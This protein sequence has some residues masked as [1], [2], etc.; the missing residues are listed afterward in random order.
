MKY[1]ILSLVAFTGMLLNSCA[2]DE[3]PSSEGIIHAVMENDLTRT[4]VT[5]EGVFTWSSGDKIWLGTTTGNIIGTL[6]SGADTPSAQFSYGAHFG[7]MTG[8]AVYPYNSGHSISGDVLNVVMPASYDISS[9]LNDTNAAMYGVNLDGTLKF[10]HMAGVMRFKFNNVPAG[11]TKFIITL[12]KKINGTFVADLTAEYPVIETSTTSVAEEKTITL[13]FNALTKTSDICLYV[14][15]PLGTY[16]SLELG[17]YDDDQPVW[18]YSNTVT[19]TISRKTLKLM[20]TVT[21]DGSIGGEIEEG[22]ITSEPQEG[23]Y[24]DEYGISHGQ[25]IKIGETIWAPVNCGYHATDYK[26]GKLYQWGRKYGQ[27]Y[28]ISYDVDV[29]TI[30]EGP[31]SLIY[32]Q[33]KDNSN[34][35]FTSSSDLNYDWLS[36]PDDKLWDSGTEFTPVKTEYDPCPKGWRVP[37]NAELSE[38]Y[39]NH[40]A[41]TTEDGLNGYWFCGT[42]SYTETVPKVF[43]P[44]AGSRN[45]YGTNAGKAGGRDDSGFYWSSSPSSNYKASNFVFTSD[46]VILDYAS[47]TYGYSVR[48]VQE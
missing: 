4:A 8:K 13:N 15:L 41:W 2:M 42:S 7:E 16:S 31:V 12:D 19:N 43:F 29:P 40:S 45:C 18:S 46:I 48:C 39:Q 5:D 34:V 14:P 36:T 9:S 26:Y 20:P 11:V 30:A 28:D 23:D 17:I 38:L 32:G 10:N 6:S 22:D 33:A 25:G 47:R 27:G 37:T 35:F 21:L 3:I 24:T 1:R 44:A